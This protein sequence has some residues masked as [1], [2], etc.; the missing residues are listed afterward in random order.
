M[1]S[2]LRTA[3]AAAAIAVVG[4]AGSASALPGVNPL[5]GPNKLTIR[6]CIPH[7]ETHHKYVG[8][9]KIG[10]RYYRVYLVY[11]VYVNRYCQKRIISVTRRY[12]PLFGFP[13][14]RPA[15]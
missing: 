9:T 13:L 1:L 7:V 10:F 8:I 11:K 15:V 6:F 5:V 3:L 4:F 2:T 14:G 12:V